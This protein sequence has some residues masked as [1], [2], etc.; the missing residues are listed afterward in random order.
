MTRAFSESE[1]VAKWGDGESMSI[2][3]NDGISYAK[4]ISLNELLAGDLNLVDH[5]DE[6]LDPDSSGEATVEAG[7]TIEI[8][9]TADD[10]STD[11]AGAAAIVLPVGE[12]SFE[13][14][15]SGVAR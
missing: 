12:V 10:G 7:L 4:A 3:A 6:E 9:G 1:T 8:S 14:D 13:E 2:D 15:E 11:R 5:D